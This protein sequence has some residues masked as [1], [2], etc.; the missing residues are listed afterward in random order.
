MSGSPRP[1]NI[2]FCVA[3]AHPTENASDHYRLPTEV[4]PRQYDLTTGTDFEKKKFTGFVKI[5]CVHR[6][7]RIVVRR[8]LAYLPQPRNCES[9]LQCGSRDF[10]GRGDPC[11]HILEHTPCTCRDKVRCLHRARI[12]DVRRRAARGD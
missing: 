8:A 7:S 11:L 1:L 5:D 10:A 6:L 2:P 4:R 9:D 3:I 12:I